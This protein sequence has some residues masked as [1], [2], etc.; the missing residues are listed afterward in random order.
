MSMVFEGSVCQDVLH[1]NAG[2]LQAAGDQD[3][4]MAG[5]WF[6]LR[7]HDCQAVLLRP[8]AQPQESLLEDR[9]LDY[10]FVGRYAVLIALALPAAAP[11]CSPRNTYSIPDAFNA[12]ERFSRLK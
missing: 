7:T 5:Q 12:A 3:G 4:P 9:K 11:S 6:L 8:A 10:S 2:I 1:S